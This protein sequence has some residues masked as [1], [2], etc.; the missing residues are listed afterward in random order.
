MEYLRGNAT[1]S[2]SA[3]FVICRH[4]NKV[5]G[6]CPPADLRNALQ[7]L[8]SH[9]DEDD[10]KKA[11]SDG[12]AA[13]LKV[14]QGIGLVKETASGWTLDPATA[15]GL[16]A[17]EGDG[18]SWFRAHLLSRINAEAMASLTKEKPA[19]LVLG[20]AWFLQQNP[21]KPFGTA[22]GTGAETSFKSLVHKDGSEVK[23]VETPEQW[24]SFM[25]WAIA[26]GLARSV[27]TGDKKVF[28]G[29]ASTAIAGQFASLPS[30]GRAE[31]WLAQL[32]EQLPIF[33]SRTLLE[34][35]PEPRSG[36]AD[37]APAVTLGLLKLEKAGA[38]KMGSAD[39]GRGV[40]AIGLGTNLRQIGR[41]TIT[42]AAA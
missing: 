23:A 7:P 24:R 14:G 28:I 3:V 1:A 20:L 39:D 12:L 40:V 41:I 37:I 30:S 6:A 18:W 27:E 4:L 8:Q 2:A 16:T 29:D 25:R 17:A 31:E 5:G 15:T 42:G 26:L 35:L 36:W 22:W 38:L 9:R 21:M 34:T 11:A 32:A 19:D 33:G 13:S 10:P